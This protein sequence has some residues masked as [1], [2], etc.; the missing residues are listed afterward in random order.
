MK[1]LRIFGVSI[2][3]IMLSMCLIIGFATAQ[4]GGAPEADASMDKKDAEKADGKAATAD[5]ADGAKEREF[6]KILVSPLKDELKMVRKALSDTEGKMEKM[7]KTICDG[8]K[9]VCGK[10]D[11]V[12]RTI[13]EKINGLTVNFQDAKTELT[14]LKIGVE[15]IK[16]EAVAAKE[17][18]SAAKQ[19]AAAAR[20]EAVLAKQEAIA[21]RQE[22]AAAIKKLQEDFDKFMSNA[23]NMDKLLKAI[24][25]EVGIIKDDARIFHEENNNKKRK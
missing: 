7:D 10:L 25:E 19:E 20:A 17:E 14:K 11:S 5:N 4:V 22:A 8:L 16:N 6:V 9:D 23:L 12:F 3:V 2:A 15:E 18:A 21:A 1:I 24:E 13:D